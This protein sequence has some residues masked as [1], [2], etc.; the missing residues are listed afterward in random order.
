MLFILSVIST[1][2]K[3]FNQIFRLDTT[4]QIVNISEYNRIKAK[5]VT[6][7]NGREQANITR[8]Q[9]FHSCSV[10]RNVY[11]YIFC[12]VEYSKFLYYSIRDGDFVYKWKN[13]VQVLTFRVRK[14]KINRITFYLILFY[15]SKLFRYM[16]SKKEVL[17]QKL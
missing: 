1:V 7:T 15:S 12:P 8:T 17:F 2:R 9:N 10:N 4:N 5:F 13:V 11:M 16:Y 6:K 3:N 14:K